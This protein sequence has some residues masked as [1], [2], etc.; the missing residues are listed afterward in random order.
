MVIVVIKVYLY[1]RFLVVAWLKET[2]FVN[3]A[4][5]YGVAQE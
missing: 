1:G 5:A 4:A 2:L 3:L